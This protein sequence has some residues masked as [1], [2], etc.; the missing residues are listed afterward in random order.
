MDPKQSLWQKQSN[1]PVPCHVPHIPVC[2]VLGLHGIQTCLPLIQDTAGVRLVQL[3]QTFPL[4]LFSLQNARHVLSE[5]KAK[6][7]RPVLFQVADD[8]WGNR[9]ADLN[10]ISNPGGSCS[11]F[12]QLRLVQGVKN[13]NLELAGCKYQNTSFRLNFAGLGQSQSISTNWMRR[14]SGSKG[15]FQFRGV[16]AF[17]VPPSKLQNALSNAI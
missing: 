16:N 3:T 1:T 13:L 5:T 17:L 6:L 4:Y 12:Q 15:I 7:A 14:S 2:S 10:P 9:Q 8:P 11:T